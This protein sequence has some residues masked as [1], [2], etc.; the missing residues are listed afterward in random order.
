VTAAAASESAAATP[1]PLLPLH[2]DR[3]FRRFWAA[4]T[5]SVFGDQ[6]SALAIPLIAVLALD[7]SPAQLGVLTSLAWLP[8][9]LFSL[10]AGVWVDRRPVRRRVMIV[11]DWLRA[12]AMAS[13]PLAW[14]LDA[15]TIWQLLGVAFAVGGLTVFFDLANA[16]YFV[17]L[18]PREQYVEANGRLSQSRSVA[19]IAG[20][21]T[22]GVLVQALTAPVA[23]VAD[24]LS[25]VFS[26]LM[27]QRT[28][29]AEPP[30]ASREE[31]ARTQLADGFRFLRHHAALRA[32]VACTSTI[33]FFNFFLLAIFILFA[34]RTLG[35]SAAAIGIVLGVG[36]VGALVG[37]FVAPRVGR[38]VG[39][40]RAVVIGAVLFPAPL[41]L[42]PL[43]QGPTWLETSML[44]VGEFLASVGVM[45]FDVNQ[46]SLIALLIPHHLRSRVA[47][48]MRFFNYGVR[49]V[50]ALLGGI[51]GGWI[52]LR[53]T[54]W[55]SV[56]GSLLGV[57]FL[58]ASPVPGL[59]EETIEVPT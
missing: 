32:G 13:I 2:R 25:F 43:A 40:G 22:A 54:M 48:V 27:L 38:L 53:T 3:A 51:L 59:R 57:I 7:A 50:G 17:G 26:A 12:A 14:W 35:L 24:A 23:V 37:A 6:V 47:G 16:S 55:I 44:L 15:L 49:P 8:H 39:I 52:G 4:S 33:N 31:R 30:S 34:S 18:V 20:P 41:A 28:P 9:L 42:F 58:L 36:A 45:V 19:Y 11:A 10:P 56:V 29:V 46:N 21:S 1:A 5:V